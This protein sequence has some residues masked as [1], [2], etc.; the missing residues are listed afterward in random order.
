MDSVHP[1]GLGGTFGGNPISCAAALAAIETI[2]SEGL[3]ERSTRI[4]KVMIDRLSSLA[5]EH[6]VI[7]DVR[8][9][10]SMVAIELVEPDGITP[11]QPATVQVASACHRSGLLV[12]TAGT[13]GNVIRLLAPLVIPDDLLEEGLDVLAEAL[14][15]P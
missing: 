8:G 6:K 13:Y 4:G 14:S 9:R 3:L 10:G 11:N 2:E 12:L 7:G 1:G 5:T 15:V